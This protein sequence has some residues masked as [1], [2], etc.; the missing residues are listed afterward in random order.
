LKARVQDL[1]RSISALQLE[2][3]QA[4]GELEGRDAWDAF[5]SDGAYSMAHWVKLQLGVSDWKAE[6]W[7]DS[8]V[9][10][11]E[12]PVVAAGLGSGELPIDK[13]VEITRFADPEEQEALVRWAK[14]V[15][16]GA[17]RREGELRA[18]RDVEEVVTVERERFCDWGFHYDGKGF[19]L[20]AQLPAAQG[21]VVA[22]ALDELASKIPVM[23]GEEGQQGIGCRRADALVA[24]CSG[25]GS[26][27]SLGPARAEIL[28]H[29]QLEDLLDAEAGAYVEA[30]PTI[31][32]SAVRR[33]L[34][35]SSVKTVI[36]TYDGTV[37]GVGKRIREPSA[38]L[39]RQLRHRDQEC[40][41]PGCGARRFTHAH[42]I[43]WWSHG[44]RTDLDNLVLICGHHHRLVHEH[45]W[46][47]DCHPDGDLSWFRP[48]GTGYRAG[49]GGD[50][51]VA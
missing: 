22:S 43:D 6:R 34:C 18:R 44:G 39:M 17:I 25:E 37:A 46:R 8:G 29:A 42:H 50:V 45:G 31:P 4:L 27:G 47:V 14:R 1:H 7:V 20:E 26:V 15:S 12:L 40:A 9:A 30:G 51:A 21:A 23:P 24:M 48:D 11:R 16:S 13:V 38:A 28:V 36:E 33:L 2:M 49:P 32:T 5:E 41:F 3:L 19:W 35:G 10:L